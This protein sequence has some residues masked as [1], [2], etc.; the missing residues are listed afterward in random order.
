MSV[1]LAHTAQEQDAI[2]L[3]MLENA[4]R[5]GDACP[6]NS[7]IA[8][9]VDSASI[10]TASLIVGRLERAGKITVRR[11]GASRQVTIVESGLSTADTVPVEMK[12]LARRKR[13]AVNEAHPEA[14]DRLAEAV[15][16]L[17][18]LKAAR[19]HLRISGTRAA[20]LWAEIVRRLGWQAQ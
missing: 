16:E 4:A 2:V 17:G 8:C 12:F 5:R 14:L 9:A 15:A 13:G 11:G 6:A 19:E 7:L 1:K 3:A 18:T 20:N 10:G